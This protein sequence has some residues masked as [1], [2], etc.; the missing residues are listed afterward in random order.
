MSYG[1]P[2]RRGKEKK[3]L[4]YLTAGHCQ[5]TQEDN[6]KR[7]H[8]QEARRHP[9]KGGTDGVRRKANLSAVICAV[10]RSLR[11]VPAETSPIPSRPLGG[12]IAH[13]CVVCFQEC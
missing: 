6:S 4:D 13:S 9:S 7:E 11:H 3:L 2:A 10:R 8:S 12:Y 5:N 1:S